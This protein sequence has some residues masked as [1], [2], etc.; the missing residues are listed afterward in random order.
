MSTVEVTINSIPTRV[1]SYT[2]HDTFMLKY[3]TDRGVPLR[4]L[5]ASDRLFSNP[6]IDI[7]SVTDVPF[8]DARFSRLTER[9]RAIARAVTTEEE[10]E[11]FKKLFPSF[12]VYRRDVRD[13]SRLIERDVNQQRATL[14]D[15]LKIEKQFEQEPKTKAGD[16]VVDTVNVD[17]TFKDFEYSMLELFDAI[18]VTRNMPYV[19]WNSVTKVYEGGDFDERWFEIEPPEGHIFFVFQGEYGVFESTTL[20]NVSLKLRGE[21]TQRSLV[22]ELLSFIAIPMTVETVRQVSVRGEFTIDETAID[23][24]IL[25]YLLFTDELASSVLTV[26]ESNALVSDKK[27]SSILYPVSDQSYIRLSVTSPDEQS[28]RLRVSNIENEQLVAAMIRK[29]LTVMDVYHA[30]FDEVTKFY[31]RWCNAY[32]ATVPSSHGAKARK[33][34]DRQKGSRLEALQEHNPDMFGGGYNKLCQGPTLQPRIVDSQ[35]A[36]EIERRDADQ[37]IEYPFNSDVYY[38]CEPIE[39]RQIGSQF[40]KYKYPGLKAN[41]RHDLPDY[42]ARFPYVPCCYPVSQKDKKSSEYYKYM[43]QL[44]G[45]DV[46][47]RPAERK[48]M[49]HTLNPQNILYDNRLGYLTFNVKNAL[50]MSGISTKNIVRLGFAA[51]GES[52][53]ACIAYASDRTITRQSVSDGPVQLLKQE[54]YASSLDNIRDYIR[55]EPMLRPELLVPLLEEAA[56]MNVFLFVDEQVVVP[57]HVNYYAQRPRSFG[58]SIVVHARIVNPQRVQCELLVDRK[59]KRPLTLTARQRDA[60]QRRFFAPIFDAHTI[61]DDEPVSHTS[62]Q[63]IASQLLD[64]GGRARLLVREDGHVY[65][66]PMPTYPGTERVISQVPSYQTTLSDAVELVNS[67]V[68]RQLVI[69][70]KARGVYGRDGTFVPCVASKPLKDVPT[71]DRSPLTHLEPARESRL[72]QFRNERIETERMHRYAQVAD[73]IEV[74]DRASSYNASSRTLRVPSEQLKTQ[75]QQTKDIC[76]APYLSSARFTS[77]PD[78]LIFSTPETLEWWYENREPD[79]PT[80][81]HLSG[82]LDPKRRSLYYASIMN[83]PIVGIQNIDNPMKQRALY[84]SYM[85]ATQRTNVGYAFDTQPIDAN[86]QILNV[87]GTS[88]GEGYPILKY[89]NGEYAAIFS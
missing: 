74:S 39:A 27:K 33:V 55:T 7:V 59:T 47:E 16:F 11:P 87:D 30:K 46:E 75:L 73:T 88:I 22:D 48:T 54:F 31:K 68:A 23:M 10:F 20:A 14:R 13:M 56:Q 40:V 86:V 12:E 32:K 83:G 2:K 41:N 24:D 69:D 1:S 71:T 25:S 36:T 3:A 67:R 57:R 21:E 52:V 79:I 60:L 81:I 70:N 63:G 62:R 82:T 80:V 29:I 9:E 17:V 50:E 77:R 5:H 28:T 58:E 4:Y 89:A 6:Q 78:Q 42:K 65:V 76:I 45:E 38:T 84:S 35:E 64:T 15:L 44:R 51:S 26:D 61:T 18:R 34:S 85:Y 43:A 8:D 66:P 19:R 72:S 49:E 53:V 37:V